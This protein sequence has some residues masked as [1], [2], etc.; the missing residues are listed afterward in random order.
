MLLHECIGDLAVFAERAGRADLVEAHETRVARNVSRD[1]GSEPASDTRWLVLL[2][3]NLKRSFG[4]PGFPKAL[5]Q[6]RRV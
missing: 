3:H 4:Q 1:Y 2:L 6:Q 5:N